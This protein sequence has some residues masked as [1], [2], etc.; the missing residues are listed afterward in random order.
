MLCPAILNAEESN[1]SF[2][3]IQYSRILP[4]AYIDQA[5]ESL[6]NQ[7]PGLQVLFVNRSSQIADATY[8]IIVYQEK[9]NTKWLYIEGAVVKYPN[10]WIFNV[11][12][13][14]ENAIE[15]IVAIMEQI[16]VLK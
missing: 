9:E 13:P 14:K 15:K 6:S 1:S 10:A 5:K 2:K 12:C 3:S 7:Y 11:K 4:H 8:S 16:A